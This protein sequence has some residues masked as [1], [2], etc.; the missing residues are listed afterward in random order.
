MKEFGEETQA[1]VVIAELAQEAQAA[2]PRVIEIDGQHYS[3]TELHPVQPP[4]YA[5]DALRVHTLAAFAE[6]VGSGDFKPEEFGYHAV[7]V[8]GPSEVELLSSL[9]TAPLYQ[10]LCYARATALP[11]MEGFKFGEFREL[12]AMVIALQALFQ[13]TPDRGIAL[14]LLGTVKDE[15]IATQLDDGVTQTVTAAAGIALVD[16]TAVP[17]P[18]QLAPY[19]T[20]PEIEQP[21]SPFVLRL[22]KDAQRG[23]VAAL[24]EADG[25][26]WRHDAIA[27]IAGYLSV[28]LPAG[29]KVLA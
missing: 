8:V 10:R 15:A 2:G 25:G 17:N 16:R 14:K 21:V 24:F 13:D 9:G 4:K 12:E 3:T 27:G 29:T 22:R 20:F 23:I 1:A 5:P 6:Y 28:L 19:R 11:R 7:H 18:V 26:A